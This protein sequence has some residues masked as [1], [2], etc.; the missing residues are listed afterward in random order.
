MAYYVTTIP[1]QR[2]RDTVLLRFDR[3]EG[4]RIIKKTIANLTDLPASMIHGIEAVVRGG[5]AFASLPEAFDIA[6]SRP[7]GHVAAVLGTARR[8]KLESMLHRQPSRQRSLAL[9][10]I[11]SQVLGPDSKRGISRRLSTDTASHSLGELLPLG[12]VSGNEL[13]AMLD[14]LLARQPWIERSL[15]KGF[16]P[17]ATLIR[18][19]LTSSDVEGRACPLARFGDN[20]DRQRGKM[21]IVVGLLCAT[22]GCPIAVQVFEGNPAD[23]STVAAQIERLRQRFRVHDIALVGDRGMLTSARIREEVKPAG[24][25]WISA[26]PNPQLARLL[27]ADTPAG[28]DRMRRL[29]RDGLMEVG[30]EDF[31]GERIML[32]LN[33]RL[34]KERSRQRDELLL[35]TEKALQNIADSVAR[36]HTLGRIGSVSGWPVR[37]NAGKCASISRW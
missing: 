13:L 25:D 19:D 11:L 36:G 30:S 3:R 31:P 2:G 7:H 27:D 23:P 8:L 29:Q 17:H 24:L 16:G 15:A 6:R 35:E 33:R 20:R 10:T 22:D 9:A 5:T 32:C 37:P 21:P 28:Q 26:L 1:N 12:S 18:Y 34:R 4:S 14:W